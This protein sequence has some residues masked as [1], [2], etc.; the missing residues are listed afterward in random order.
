[1]LLEPMNMHLHQLKDE[2]RTCLELFFLKEKSYKDVAEM[3]GYSIKEVKSHIQN[4]KRNLRIRMSD[5]AEK[6]E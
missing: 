2:Q 4:G 5:D 1:M 6:H 3:T